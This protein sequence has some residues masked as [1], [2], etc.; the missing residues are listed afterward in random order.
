MGK[1]VEKILEEMDKELKQNEVLFAK[2]IRWRQT[3]RFSKL[4]RVKA[5]PTEYETY[6][7]S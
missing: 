7:F 5:F 4:N 3:R 2:V 1:T 6:E